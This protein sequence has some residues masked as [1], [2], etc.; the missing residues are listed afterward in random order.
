[1]PLQSA[2]QS[3]GTPSP[4]QSGSHSSGM[5]LALQSWLVPSEMSHSSGMP[6]AL[7][8]WLVP[9][10]MSWSSGMPLPLQSSIPGPR[11]VPSTSSIA[12]STIDP[13]PRSEA[14]KRSCMA[15]VG[16]STLEIA[17]SCSNQPPLLSSPVGPTVSTRDQ[18]EPPSF[19]RYTSKTSVFGEDP[20]LLEYQRQ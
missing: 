18:L 7:Q 3:S 1:M 4:S 19:E 20:W 9:S 14:T 2:S 6:L 15:A 17:N 16:G 12:A 8:S 13:D 10:E 11:S 5:P